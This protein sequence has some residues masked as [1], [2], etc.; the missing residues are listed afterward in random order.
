MPDSD[1]VESARSGRVG[2]LRGGENQHLQY[3]TSR[4]IH[5]FIIVLIHVQLPLLIAA[6]EYQIG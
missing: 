4:Y 1:A 6:F 5:I 2:S 3:N